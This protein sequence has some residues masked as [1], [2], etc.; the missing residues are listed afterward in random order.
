MSPVPQEKTKMPS[1]KKPKPPT[2]EMFYLLVYIFPSALYHN[3]LQNYIIKLHPVP[4]LHNIF[5][6][7]AVI[8]KIHIET[9]F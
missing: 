8:L 6:P 9:I 3:T 1:K 4:L 7:V 5:L 2:Q